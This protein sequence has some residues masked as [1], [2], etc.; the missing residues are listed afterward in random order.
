MSKLISPEASC[1]FECTCALILFFIYNK[2]FEVNGNI[3]PVDEEG[4]APQARGN[5]LMVR[6][7]TLRSDSHPL[8]AE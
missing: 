3:D 7:N 2:H 4:N 1:G 8:L 5:T 6:L